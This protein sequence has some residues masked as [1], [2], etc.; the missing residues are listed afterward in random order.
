MVARGDAVA[1]RPDEEE[2]LAPIDAAGLAGAPPGLDGFGVPKVSETPAEM[3]V[4]VQTT[5]DVVGG[6]PDGGDPGR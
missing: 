6:P 3:V 1:R 4:T 5:G 2:P